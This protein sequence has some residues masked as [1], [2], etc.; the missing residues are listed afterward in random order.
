MTTPPKPILAMYATAEAT[1]L[2]EKQT[3]ASGLLAGSSSEERLLSR[4]VEVGATIAVFLLLNLFLNFFNKYILTP[5]DKGGLG[6]SFPIFQVAV[7][8]AFC[9]VVTTIV[10]ELYPAAVPLSVAQFKRHWKEIV[11]QYVLTVIVVV[12][13]L[14]SLVFMG[15][16][17]NQI[18]KCTGPLPTAAFAFC[19]ERKSMP[20]RLLL[21]MLVVVSGAVLSVPYGQPEFSGVGC[22][23]A[24]VAVCAGAART[25]LC[26]LLMRDE[27]ENGMTPIVLVWYTSLLATCTLPLVWALYAKER[28]ASI[29]FMKRLPWVGVG[30][31]LSVSFCALLFNLV[32]LHFTRITSSVTMAVVSIVKIV[33]VVNLAALLIDHTQELRIWMG[34]LVFCLGLTMYTW[35]ARLDWKRDKKATQKVTEADTT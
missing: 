12:C 16:S 15:L 25:S 18:I 4:N 1:T 3:E 26:A 27:K 9:L 6:F 14:Y 22:I 24:L 19:I 7:D 32:G 13:N 10:W 8:S 31:L 34:I 29:T 35:W 11:V 23:L 33:V 2:R 30:C 17:L 28:D 20:L 21:A 5:E